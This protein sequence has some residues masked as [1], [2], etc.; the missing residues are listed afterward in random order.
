MTET[1]IKTDDSRKFY[2]TL[3]NY[4]ERDLLEYQAYLSYQSE[5]HLRN[6]KN[7]VLFFFYASVLSVAITAVILNY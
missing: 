7:N 1:N 3:E 5:Q 6:I 2:Q 4:S